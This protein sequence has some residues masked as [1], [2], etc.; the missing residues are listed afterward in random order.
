MQVTIN[1]Q[2]HEFDRATPLAA[3]LQRLE[4]EDG[5]IAVAVNDAV[6]PRTKW[7]QVMLENGDRV[8]IIHAVQ[9][10]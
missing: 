6:V 8:E 3:A 2:N 7:G 1:G 10:G 4:I 5:G 9:G